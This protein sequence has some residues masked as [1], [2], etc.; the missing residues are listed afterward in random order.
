MTKIQI[1]PRKLLGFKIGHNTAAVGVKTGAK[2]G[3]KPNG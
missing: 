1:D 3:T 2:V